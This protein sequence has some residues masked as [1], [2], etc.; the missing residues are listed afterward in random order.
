[1]KDK[2]IKRKIKGIDKIV[3]LYFKEKSLGKTAKILKVSR[4]RV[5][6]LLGNAGY[7]PD[8]LRKCRIEETDRQIL[9]IILGNKKRISKVVDLIT[10]CRENGLNVGR[11]KATIIFR[12]C[13]LTLYKGLHGKPFVRM[14]KSIKKSK[15]K[16]TA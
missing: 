5:S 8:F 14:V 16:K 12:N 2:R 7:N 11:K 9:G 13:G 4:E 15:F 6:Q 3:R 10:L 1:L